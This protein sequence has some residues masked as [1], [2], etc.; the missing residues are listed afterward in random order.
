[1]LF[2][3]MMP[4]RGVETSKC[5][6]ARFYKLHTSKDLCEPLSMIVPRKVQVLCSTVYNYSFIF[7]KNC[8]CCFQI[9][10]RERNG[11]K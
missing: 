8:V 2:E 9:S 7:F 1:M 3:G 5:E 10:L 11:Y 6:I 4:K